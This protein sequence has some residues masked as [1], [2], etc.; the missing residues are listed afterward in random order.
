MNRVHVLLLL[1]TLSLAACSEEVVEPT[2]VRAVRFVEVTNDDGSRQRVFSGVAKAG[3]QSRLSFRV[4]GRVLT[5]P[6]NIGDSVKKGQ[7]IAKIDAAD[8]QLQ[9]QEARAA[10]AQAQAQSRNAKS[11]YERSRALYENQNASKQDLD[12]A[13]AQYDSARAS[14]A[15]A[16]QQ[17][18]LLRRQL[19]YTHL[20]APAAGVITTVDVEE[21][22]NVQ[23]GQQI[24]TLQVG[25][26]IEVSVNV[27]QSVISKIK[28]G[29]AVSVKFDALDGKVFKGECAEVGV[30]SIQGGSTFP[31]TVR[32]TEGEELARAG[33]S[34]EVTFQFETKSVGVIDHVVPGSAVGEDRKGRFVFILKPD[35]NGTG[36]VKRRDVVIG[37]LTGEGIEITNGIDKG[38]L[39]VTAGVT[40]IQDGQTVRAPGTETANPK[41]EAPAEEKAE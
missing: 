23:A 29:D 10:A 38:E 4:N 12:S 19:D 31:V 41:T 20:T 37:S 17:V 1:S 40:K 9:L 6:V 34:V 26:Q 11:T 2:L 24:A 36:I 32:L 16:S 39:I 25:N 7:T 28:Q 15:S 21:N 27:P 22:E 33:M 3:T 30:S 18:Q 14:V 35:G 5:V 13:R 8:S